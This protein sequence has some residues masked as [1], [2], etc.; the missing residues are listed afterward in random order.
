MSGWTGYLYTLKKFVGTSRKPAMFI[1]EVNQLLRPGYMPVETGYYRLPNGQMYIAALTRK[2]GRHSNWVN[3]CFVHYFLSTTAFND[4]DIKKIRTAEWNSKWKPK[5]YTG[6]SQTGEYL[7]GGNVHRFKLI[8]NDPAKYFDTSRFKEANVGAVICG[9]TFLLDG[10]PE[11]CI[12]HVV[13][14]TP[15]GCEIKTRAWLFQA[16]EEVARL[17]M[18]RFMSLGD[19]LDNIDKTLR[20]SNDSS[21]INSNVICKYC[22]SSQV[23]KNGTRIDTQYWLCKNCGRSFV[24]NQALPRMKYPVHIISNAVSDYY[25]GNSLNHIRKGIEKRSNYLPSTSTVYEWIRKFTVLALETIKGYRPE[26]GNIW[27]I[28]EREVRFS[29]RSYRLVTIIDAE[30]LFLLA[31]KLSSSGL[32]PDI[33]SLAPSTCGKFGSVPEKILIGPDGDRP[34]ISKITGWL[35][36]NNINLSMIYTE[37]MESLVKE[38]LETVMDR[39]KP[40]NSMDINKGTQ[41]LLEGFALHYNYIRLH[42]S[43]GKT[44]AQASGI[45]LPFTGWTDLFKQ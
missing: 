26:V 45:E 14:D 17:H 31:A 2:H 18:E 44:P 36:T 34:E 7:M 29:G 3:W 21:E 8:F 33:E 43:L 40:M 39:F 37:Q 13:R 27:A 24:N 16:T 42:G 12:I 20:R 9:D 38:W 5:Q 22:Q 1:E 35:T 32:K 15:T 4:Q 41:T 11:G 6:I 10:T 25:A 28:D 19:V 23:I 30:S